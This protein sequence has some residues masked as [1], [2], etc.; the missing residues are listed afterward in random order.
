MKKPEV[1]EK[2][3]KTL[4]RCNNCGHLLDPRSIHMT[5]DER[6]AYLAGSFLV[7]CRKCT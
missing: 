2:N 4:V 5:E 7:N 1:V 6:K 3:G